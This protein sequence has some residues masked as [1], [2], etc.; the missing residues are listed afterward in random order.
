MGSSNGRRCACTLSIRNRHSAAVAPIAVQVDH[1]ERTSADT[2]RVGEVGD[3]EPV[4]TLRAGVHGGEDVLTLHVHAPARS[5]RPP[6]LGAG[7]PAGSPQRDACVDLPQH[8][9][10]L[11]A[12][13]QPDG[14]AAGSLGAEQGRVGAHSHRP[15]AGRDPVAETAVDPGLAG[16]QGRDRLAAGSRVVELGPHH[17]GQQAAARVVGA[18]AD[19]G[20][21]GHREHRPAGHRQ[22]ARE[23]GGGGDERGA[24]MHPE[25]PAGRVEARR[26]RPAGVVRWRAV[27]RRGEQRVRC[28]QLVGLESVDGERHRQAG[29]PTS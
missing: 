19:P 12:L 23:R 20:D 28:A 9:H 5:H 18:H 27:D 10:D 7:D 13:Q 16:P 4:V 29:R 21:R 15:A 11:A 3:R 22:V 25:R 26:H 6:T 1:V 24:R 2:V 14:P 8:R 17:R